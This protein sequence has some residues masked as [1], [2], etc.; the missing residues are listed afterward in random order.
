MMMGHC[1]AT[2]RYRRNKAPP[3]RL[4]CENITDDEADA[5][6]SYRRAEHD[7][8]YSESMSLLGLIEQVDADISRF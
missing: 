5:P 1:N 3:A 8:R 4:P 2:T 6:F 7:A